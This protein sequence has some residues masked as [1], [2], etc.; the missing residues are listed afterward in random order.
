MVDRVLSGAMKNTWTK[1]DRWYDNSRATQSGDVTI[2]QHRS[3]VHPVG[4]TRG[5]RTWSFRCSL[6]LDG[7]TIELK[8]KTIPAARKEVDEILKSN[9]PTSR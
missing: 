5:A 3:L 8:S 9:L 4:I 1:L 7:Q 6:R 2:W